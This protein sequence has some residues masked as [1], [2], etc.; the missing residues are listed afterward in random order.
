MQKAEG[1]ERGDIR[2]MVSK[3]ACD[4]LKYHKQIFMTDLVDREEMFAPMFCMDPYHAPLHGDLDQEAV[5]WRGQ[6]RYA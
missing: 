5:F 1:R 3:N 2:E 6:D 4:L